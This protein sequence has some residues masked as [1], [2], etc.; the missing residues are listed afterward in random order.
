MTVL[1]NSLSAS[2]TEII[3]SALKENNRATLVGEKTFG[4]GS[5]QSVHTLS[6]ESGLAV[7]I[8]EFFTGNCI[9]I[10]DK[11]VQPQVV[12]KPS[13]SEQAKLNKDSSLFGSAEDSV[14][15]RAIAVLRS[16]L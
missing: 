11:G 15:S 6:N 3:A 8:A 1:V 12:V 10:Q 9:Q 4:Q 5:I 7:T 14:Y 13:Q 16:Q 2:G